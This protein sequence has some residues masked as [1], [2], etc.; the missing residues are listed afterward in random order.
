MSMK[1]GKMGANSFLYE[2]RPRYGSLREVVR[3]RE[4]GKTPPYLYTSL[5]PDPTQREPPR[6]RKARLEC[7]DDNMA[8]K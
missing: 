6:R 4:V 1:G 7:R 3:A 5:C 8:Q 2:A